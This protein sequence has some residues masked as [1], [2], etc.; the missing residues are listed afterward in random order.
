MDP[1]VSSPLRYLPRRTFSPTDHTQEA[2][3]VDEPD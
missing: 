1:D 3:A 2:V